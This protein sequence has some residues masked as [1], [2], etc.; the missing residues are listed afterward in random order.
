MKK[1]DILDWWI[2]YTYKKTRQTLLLLLCFYYFYFFLF[3]YIFSTTQQ[4]IMKIFSG[5]T[6]DKICKKIT[7]HFLIVTFGPEIFR[8]YC[9]CVQ[10]FSKVSKTELSNFQCRKIIFS[11][12]ARRISVCRHCGRHRKDTKKMNF[13][14]FC[15]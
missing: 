1:V 14:F 3:Y 8:I 2:L 7:R 10:F 11:R 6:K 9:F 13:S 12:N 15:F 4:P 5:L